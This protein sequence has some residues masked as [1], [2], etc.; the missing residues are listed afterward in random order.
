[1]PHIFSKCILCIKKNYINMCSSPK[2]V[3]FSDL[4]RS[5]KYLTSRREKLCSSFG[6]RQR[7]ESQIILFHVSMSIV[8]N[9]TSLIRFS[10][11]DY[12]EKKSPV[13][14]LLRISKKFVLASDLSSFGK[15][16]KIFWR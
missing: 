2:K 4:A 6:V 15:H 7:R 5:A 12:S 1:M 9:V 14:Q 3:N 8:S 11:F 16:D 13:V 10:G